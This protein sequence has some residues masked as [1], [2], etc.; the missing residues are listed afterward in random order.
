MGNYAYSTRAPRTLDAREQAAILKVTGQHKD[1]F[2]DHTVLAVALATA[3]REHEIAGL[4]VGDVY[5]PDGNARTRVVLS[6]F[7]RSNSDAKSQ[8]VP[9]SE[10]LRAK[11]AKFRTWK[12]SAG[13][14]LHPGAP[15]FVSRLGKRLSTRQ[16]RHMFATWQERAGLDRK[17]TF[18]ELRHTAISNLYRSTKDIRVAQRFARHAS[19]ISTTVYAH[20]GDEDV[21][22]AV[23]N[24][25][26]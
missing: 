25:R 4:N 11:L 17:F 20:P 1:G 12:E 3:L 24:L 21:E 10:N 5:T 6:V 16:L 9:L 7:K 14:P 8:E 18:H 15:L 13:E 2:R 23:Q 26:C 22:R 19:V